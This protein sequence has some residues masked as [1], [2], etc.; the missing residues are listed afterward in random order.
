MGELD[1][2]VAV[3][4][5][6]TAGIG[7]ATAS[8]LA[9]EG[10]SVVLADIDSERGERAARALEVQGWAAQFVRT[11]VADDE[12]AGIKGTAASTHE[13]TPRTGPVRSR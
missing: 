12:S 4:T 5:G 2:K 1:G 7:W 10:A 9:Y 3:V 8:A 6:A 11:D 13:C